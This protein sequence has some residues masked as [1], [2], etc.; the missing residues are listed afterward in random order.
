MRNADVLVLCHQSL[1]SR[2]RVKQKL[3]RDRQMPVPDSKADRDRC[4]ST[5]D[6]GKLLR[7]QEIKRTDCVSLSTRNRHALAICLRH[8]GRER[9][10]G[11]CKELPT[12]EA[13]AEGCARAGEG[14]QVG[15]VP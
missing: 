13:E 11:I 15:R 14:D 12:P 10:V 7:N 5:T 3:K 4:R 1:A 6:A 8:I 2:R 9:P